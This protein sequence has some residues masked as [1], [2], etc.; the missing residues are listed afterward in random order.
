MHARAWRVRLDGKR[1]C[2]K[3]ICV[4]GAA[5]LGVWLTDARAC[6]QPVQSVVVT[7]TAAAAAAASC[8]EKK[9]DRWRHV[10]VHDEQG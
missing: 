6:E 7:P 8:A 3:R 5:V 10:D 4:P 9:R 2:V 1:R